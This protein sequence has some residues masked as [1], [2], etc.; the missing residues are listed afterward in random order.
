MK[1]DGLSWF[2]TFGELSYF[3]GDYEIETM[4][5]EFYRSGINVIARRKGGRNYWQLCS[6][7]RVVDFKEGV[8]YKSKKVAQ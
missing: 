8:G 1:A 3:V 7:S 4:V 6:S 5:G 2:A